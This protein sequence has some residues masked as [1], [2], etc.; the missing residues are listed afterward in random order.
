MLVMMLLNLRIALI[1]TWSTSIS[2]TDVSSLVASLHGEQGMSEEQVFPLDHSPL[3]NHSCSGY[4]PYYNCSRWSHCTKAGSCKCFC[5]DN[6]I[7]E[8]D[9]YGNRVSILSCYCLT[10]DEVKNTTEVGW[11][12]YNCRHP[13]KVDLVGVHSAYT[14]LTQNVSKLNDAT[15]SNFERTG[16]LCGKCKKD[17]YVRAYS[18]DIS[19][20]RCYGR[21]FDIFKYLVAAFLPLT[22]FSLVIYFFQINIHSSRLQGF[23][24]LSQTVGSAV[25]GRQIFIYLKNNSSSSQL[26][27]IKTLISFYSIWNLDFLRSFNFD[28]CLQFSILT[29]LSLDFLIAFYPFLLIAI[30]Y[31]VILLHDYGSKPVLILLKPFKKLFRLYKINWNV[32]SS[33]VDAFSTFL[34]LS[35]AKLLGVCTDLLSPVQVCDTSGSERCRWA[36]F[37]NATLPYLGTEHIPY[38]SLAYLIIV[39][40]VMLPMLL[41]L[42]YP[43]C[44]F[45]KVMMLL[46]RRIQIVIHMF[47]DSYQKCYKNG[48][49]PDNRDCRWFSAVLI[50]VRITMF[51]M[52]TTLLPFPLEVLFAIIL[53]LTAI[54]TILAEPFKK[55]FEYLTTDLV[56]SVLLIAILLVSLGVPMISVRY[57]FVGL[58]V[59]LFHLGFISSLIFKW[60]IQQKKLK[61]RENTI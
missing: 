60:I 2:G 11:C 21:W 55:E 34:F 53:V 28:I 44:G 42:L 52:Y 9:S 14:P 61:F 16:T 3:L 4:S 23:V 17:S 56:V 39:L 25:M 12:L 10:F 48:I 57:Y 31:V 37:V 59:S 1:L 51:L 47:L 5:N 22:V 26:Y 46:P 38:A 35:Q 6:F 43:L 30:I 20:M 19:C 40:F 41:L 29:I 24:F 32:K 36:V 33:A 54:L 49:G 27:A 58:A 50:S 13:S 18:Y 7:F 15:C 8:C 45:Q